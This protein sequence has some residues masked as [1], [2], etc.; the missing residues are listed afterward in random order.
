[1][2]AS[3]LFSVAIVPLISA[4][5]GLGGVFLGGM[6]TS[7]NQKQ[8]RRQC[9][10]RDQLAEFY[11]PMAGIRERLRSKGEIRLKVSNAAG[12]VW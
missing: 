7:R 11:A 4:A 2:A 8:E 5:S 10:V 6:L 1:M 3:D 12:T 9:F